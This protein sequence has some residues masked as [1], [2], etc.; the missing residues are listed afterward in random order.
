MYNGVRGWY[1]I[2][3][4]VCV[5]YGVLGIY[6]DIIYYSRI[7]YLM[8]FS[9]Y[10]CGTIY[11]ICLVYNGVWGVYDGVCIRGLVGLYGREALWVMEFD[12]NSQKVG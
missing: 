9:V 7:W 1:I 4:E 8:I 6:L 3:S 11:N 2:L 12:K 5:C 10:I